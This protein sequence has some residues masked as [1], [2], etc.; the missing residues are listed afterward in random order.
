V[1]ADIP[2]AEA[3]PTLDAAAG[4]A[5][6]SKLRPCPLC[7]GKPKVIGGCCFGGLLNNLG[8]E[9]QT[10]GLKTRSGQFEDTQDLIEFWNAKSPNE[11][12]SA[13]GGEVAP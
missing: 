12:G 8:I 7:G 6:G 10:C 5:T 2:Q 4:L 11:Q 13:T 1:S 9:C 3:S